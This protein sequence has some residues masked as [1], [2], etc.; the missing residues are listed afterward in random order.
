V[1]SLA[2]AKHNSM[3]RHGAVSPT[4]S[5][6]SRC[7]TSVCASPSP[8]RRLPIVPPPSRCLAHLGTPSPTGILLSHAFLPCAVSTTT[9]PSS[10]PCPSSP[11][12]RPSPPRSHM[13]RLAQPA[14]AA[15]A[16]PPRATPHTAVILLIAWWDLRY[17]QY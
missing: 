16:H 2:S 12:R 6:P 7:R 1:A 3:A 8:S 4:S 15:Q 5:H 10:P 9:L 14:V 13:R 17:R 11:S